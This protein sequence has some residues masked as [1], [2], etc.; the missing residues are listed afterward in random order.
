M[1]FVSISHKI[2]PSRQSPS[3]AMDFNVQP[4]REKAAVN[5]DPVD[6]PLS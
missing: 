6:T 5:P 2:D 3:I 4:E 1:V